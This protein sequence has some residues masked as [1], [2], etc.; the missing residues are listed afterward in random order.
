MS[1]RHT[2]GAAAFAARG[3]PASSRKLNSHNVYC[4][5]LNQVRA[6]TVLLQFHHSGSSKLFMRSN[7]VKEMLTIGT[8]LM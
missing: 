4:K 8:T 6:T 1:K 3:A 5:T 2:G 7:V